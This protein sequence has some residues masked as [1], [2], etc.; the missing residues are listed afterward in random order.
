[1]CF[2]GSFQAA[3]AEQGLGSLEEGGAIQD[4]RGGHLA[5]GGGVGG[6]REGIIPC[7][8]GILVETWEAKG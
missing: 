5:S 2:S 3:Q 8:F 4:Y 6:E 7:P 1:M